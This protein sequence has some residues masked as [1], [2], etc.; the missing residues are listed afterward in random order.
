MKKTNEKSNLWKVVDQI[1]WEVWDPIGVNACH[2]AR[3]E[4]YSYVNGVVRLLKDNTGSDKIAKHLQELR[5][6]IIGL[7]AKFEEDQK[8]ADLLIEKANELD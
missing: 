8:V 7:S 2:A 1:L 4:Y 5:T 3:N 6:E